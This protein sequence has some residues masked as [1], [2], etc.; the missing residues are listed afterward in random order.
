MIFFCSSHPCPLRK[1]FPESFGSVVGALFVVP[2]L[3]RFVPAFRVCPLRDPG[4]VDAG[5]AVFGDVN[6]GP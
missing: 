6:R 5:G 3:L 4:E 2:S 1:I